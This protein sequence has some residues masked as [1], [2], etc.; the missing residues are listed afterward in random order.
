MP[1]P[2]LFPLESLDLT[3][4]VMS[5]EEIYS[6]LA[7]RHEFMLLDGVL[8]VDLDEGVMVAYH[9]V[10]EDEWWVRGH[11]PGRPL[12]PGVLMLEV[13]AQM[14]SVY[15]SLAMGHKRFVVF[16]GL[17][18]VKFRDAVTPP[19]RLLILGKALEVRPRRTISRFQGLVGDK[20]VVEGQ[21]TGLPVKS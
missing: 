9:D 3:K 18:G 20:L 6:Y 1:P 13:A 12:M 8:H 19:A 17:D 14:C 2:L 10:R 4:T 11:V 5:Q 16:G 21:I 7:H 15:Y